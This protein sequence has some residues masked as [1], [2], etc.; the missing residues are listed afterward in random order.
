MNL[1]MLRELSHSAGSDDGLASE[2][3]AKVAFLSRPDSYSP[4][5]RAIVRRETHMSWVFLTGEAVYKLKKPVRLSYL[6]F[7]TLSRR[8]RACRAELRLNRRLAADVYR[9]VVPLKRTGDGF[10]L[11]GDGETVDWLVHMRQLDERFTLDRLIADGRLTPP[12]I[13]RLVAVLARFYRTAEPALIA[14]AAYLGELRR[15]LAYNRRVLLDTRLGMP[16]GLVRGID[17]AQQAFLARHAGMIAARL[18][19]RHIVDGHGDLRPEHICLDHKVRIIDAL[20]F[21]DR[22]RIVDPFD[23]VAFLSLECERLG[24]RWAADLLRRRMMR[25]LRDGPAQE[26]FTFYSCYRATLR[27]RL[28]IAHLL[29]PQPRTP[30]KWP[31]LAA[32]YLRLAAQNARRLDTMLRTR[33]GR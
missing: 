13:E 1:D 9:D 25:A 31:R 19:H 6:D 12:Q 32:D 3:D 17:R 10:A 33:S 18:R 4:A 8:E 23:E 28:A 26:L 30:E 11:G 5:A 24:A 29:E 7:S 22:M 2:L 14:P 27:A 21:N 20:E 16:V 15:M